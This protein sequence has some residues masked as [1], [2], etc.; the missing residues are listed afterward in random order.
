LRRIVVLSFFPTDNNDQD[1]GDEQNNKEIREYL[2]Y[3]FQFC[4]PVVLAHQLRII[5][6]PRNPSGAHHIPA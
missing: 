5:A 2:Q 1:K 3:P 6:M 4:I